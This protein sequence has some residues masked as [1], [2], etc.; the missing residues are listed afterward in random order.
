MLFGEASRFAIRFPSLI[1]GTLAIPAAYFLGKEVN[2]KTLGL[3]VAALISC[4][5]PFFYYSQNARAYPLVMLGF[6][7]VSYF[8][9]KMYRG[10]TSYKTIAGLSPFTALC[11][12]SHYYSL[13]PIAILWL[14]LFWKR[15][16]AIL[17]AGIITFVLMLPMALMFDLTQLAT[18]TNHG[19]FN[20]LWTPPLQMA[21]ELP[22]EMLCWSWIIIVPLAIYALIKYNEPILRLFAIVGTITPLLLIPLSH[23]TAIMPRY[24][25]LVSPLLL[26]MAMYPISGIIDNQTTNGKKAI[27]FI[28]IIFLVFIFNYGSIVMWN[29]FD[30]CPLLNGGEAFL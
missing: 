17:T 1:I 20:V 21:I 30:T 18:R 27:L 14:V 6:I 10:D 3:L 12:W 7:C 2:G 25:I 28:S 23:F 26:V 4:M 24:A 8:F 9:V 13:V 15:R 5:F 22:N 11:F 16:I 19:I 29:T